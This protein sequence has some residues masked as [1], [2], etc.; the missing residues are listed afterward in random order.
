L[1]RIQA[2]GDD[3]L[4]ELPFGLQRELS[5]EGRVEQIEP[6]K[7]RFSLSPGPGRRYRLAQVDNYRRLGR[8]D[9][10]YRPPCELRLSARA[11][12]GSL[13]G[14]WGFGLWNDPFGMS[15]LTGRGLRSPALPNTAWFFFASP[16]NYLS[17]RE[18]LPANGALAATFRS[19][20]WPAVLLAFGAPAMALALLPA[21]RRRLRRLA[22]AFVKQ[23]AASLEI[24]PACLH[25]YRLRWEAERA[26]FWVDGESVLETEI[27]PQGLLGL[28]IWID[29]QYMALPPDGKFAYGMLE[30]P[31]PA[32][33]EVSELKVKAD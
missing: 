21:G 20:L 4:S 29:N 25:T 3:G 1:I 16:E 27:A 28:V 17:L 12:G 10:P 8:G 31:Q 9:F 13:P 7:W 19:P 22:R 23:D 18:D 11:S 26:Q 33:V 14:T 15:A 24:D 32:W 2:I 6:S 30:N 5:E